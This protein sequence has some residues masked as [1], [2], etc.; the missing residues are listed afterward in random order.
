MESEQVL[1]TQIYSEAI[2]RYESFNSRT[3]PVKDIAQR[4]FISHQQLYAVLSGER[5]FT[6]Q[7][8]EQFFLICNFP[9]A[10]KRKAQMCFPHLYPPTERKGKK[11]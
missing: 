3:N 1:R 6:L 9:E 4:L 8:E 2:E 10:Y 5:Y 7:Q 11:K